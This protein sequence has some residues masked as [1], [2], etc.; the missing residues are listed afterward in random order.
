MCN[1]MHNCPAATAD[2]WLQKTVTKIQASDGYKNG[3]AIFVLFDEGAMR[4]LGASA[5]LATIVISDSLVQPGY[6]SDVHFDHRSYVATIEDIF[7]MPRIST[8]K[9]VASMDEFFKPVQATTA[10]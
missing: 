6:K 9:D 1:D 4:F 10:P 5:S 2:A 7:G 8:T 3:G